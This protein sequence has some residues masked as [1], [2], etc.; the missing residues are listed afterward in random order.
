MALGDWLLPDAPTERTRLLADLQAIDA[1]LQNLDARVQALETAPPTPRIFLVNDAPAAALGN[2]GDGAINLSNGNV[3][4]REGGAW[5][6]RGA[7]WL[8]LD[9]VGG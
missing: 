6:F 5:V 8:A 4:M 2:D 3:F 9:G 7:F 1:G